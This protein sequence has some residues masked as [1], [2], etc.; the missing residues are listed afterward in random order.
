[1]S[2]E[3]SRW[4]L[5]CSHFT[6][7]YSLSQ[8][9]MTLARSPSNRFS[10]A[11]QNKTVGFNTSAQGHWLQSS[12]LLWVAMYFVISVGEDCGSGSINAILLLPS[13]C[14]QCQR[15]QLEIRVSCKQSKCLWH[16]VSEPLPYTAK[17]S[18]L[19]L[20]QMGPVLWLDNMVRLHQSPKRSG[21]LERNDM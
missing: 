3:E 5:K 1:M 9:R 18:V 19:T 15:N 16:S 10:G 12:N 7:S 21:V 13:V 14:E 4:R 11:K 6:P 20:F 17:Y 8:R 2:L